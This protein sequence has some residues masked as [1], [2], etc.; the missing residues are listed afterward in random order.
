MALLN[1]TSPVAIEPVR[2]NKKAAMAPAV[3][4]PVQIV[5]GFQAVGSAKDVESIAK[6]RCVSK[7]APDI[8]WYAIAPFAGGHLFECHEGGSGVAYLP[9]V[10]RELSLNMAAGEVHVPSGDRLFRI[11]MRDG[12]PICLK[13]SE[14]ESKIALTKSTTVLPKPTGKMKPAVK[15]GDGFIQVGAVLM[16]FGT[17]ALFASIGYYFVST[18]T[19]QMS[20]TVAHEQLPHRQWDSIRRLR[21]DQYVSRLRYTDGRWQIDFADNPKPPVT[22]PARPPHIPQRAQPPAPAPDQAP[23][24]T[25]TQPPAAQVHP[26]APT[27]TPPTAGQPAP[28]SKATLQTGT[29]P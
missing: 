5:F 28:G 15:S 20:K 7:L 29:N 19:E 10:I 8:S 4:A 27:V 2:E 18:A 1:D 9:E 26:S 25:P 3:E 13:L 6:E 14:Q 21:T 12:H 22:Q 11:A 23:Q 16:A 17:I 24:N